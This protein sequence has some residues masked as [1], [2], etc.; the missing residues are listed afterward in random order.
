MINFTFKKIKYFLSLKIF[1]RTIIL[2]IIAARFIQLIFLFNLPPDRLYQIMATQNLVSGHG[3]SIAHVIPGNLSEIIYEPL[4]KWPPL[5]SLLLLPFYSLSNH[6]YVIAGLILD[7]SFAIFLIFIT[8]NILKILNIQIYLINIYTL[9]TGFVIYPFYIK[10]Y[11][12]AIATTFFLFAIYLVLLYLAS[13]KQRNLKLSGIII[14]L[15]LCG[16]TKYLYMPVIFIIPL[17]LIIKGTAD[18]DLPVKRAGY[19]SILVIAGILGTFLLYQKTISG[20]A[21]YIRQ[22]IRG[23]FPQNLALLYPVFPAS[24]INP[25]TS[26]L[27]LYKNSR[28]DTF[29]YFAYQWIN[30][31]MTAFFLL[32][33]CLAI[34]KKGFKQLSTAKIFFYLTFFVSFAILILLMLLSIRVEKESGYWTYVQEARYYGLIIILLQLSIFIFYYYNKNLYKYLKYGF[35]FVLLLMLPDML[36][37]II[38]STNRITNFKKEEPNWQIE[39]K[40]QKYAD[41]II[42]RGQK[43]Y[44]TENTIIAGSSSYIN[45]RISLYSH[46]PV[47]EDINKINKLSSLNTKTSVLLLVVLREDALKD[48]ASFLSLKEKEDAGY[49][50]GFYFYTVYVEPH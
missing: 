40:F 23:Y 8:R 42:K 34:Y 43:I 7:I 16:F 37:G 35:Y 32:R 44:G 21:L 15:L 47:L 48:F 24:L 6:S 5:Y 30:L 22:P 31:F 4:I 10:P 9:I 2:V 14:S 3:I 11:S 41:D 26:E 28:F 45:N 20:S 19:F 50:S 17:L 27:I 12:D 25:E 1:S 36:R 46:I 33:G 13:T 39:L 18:N 29:I 38:F 49:F